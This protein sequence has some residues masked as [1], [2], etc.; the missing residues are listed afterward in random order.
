MIK[1]NN[2]E[3]ELLKCENCSAH[4]HSAF[5]N[6]NSNQSQMIDG[7]RQS[8]KF[9]P[10]NT[11]VYNKDGME[12]F[13]C[14]QEGHVKI[15]INDGK[16]QKTIRICGP[17]DLIGLQMP[18]NYSIHA[19]DAVTLCLIDANAFTNLQM[20]VP[21]ISMGI[22][23]NLLRTISSED[24][25]LRGLENHSVK[26]RVAATLA[27]LSDRFGII[28]Q[29]CTMIDF[30]VDRK[31]LAQLSGTVVESLARVLTEL[32]NEKIIKRHGRKIQI[33]N[34]SK[35]QEISET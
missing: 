24:E 5:Q 2:F 23:Q 34:R 11:I 30:T 12:N 31:S 26:N 21:E 9:Q 6:L 22:I 19:L 10:E 18:D 25:Q 16:N 8:K 1:T 33:L 32:E 17:G 4:C 28:D 14:I 27:N 3:K 29:Q 13:F 20:K 7:V 15:E 35:L